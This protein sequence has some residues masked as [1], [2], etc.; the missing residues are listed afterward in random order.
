MIYLD[1]QASTPIH[2]KVRSRMIEVLQSDIGAN[3]HS[4]HFAGQQAIKIIDEARRDLAH[5]F[6]VDFAEIIFTSGATE[7]NNIAIQGVITQALQTRQK[8]EVITSP[9]EHSAVLEVLQN[10]C[11]RYPDRLTVKYLSITPEGI[12]QPESLQG[13]INERTILVTVMHANNEIGTIQPI[14]ALATQVKNTR[15]KGKYPVFHSDGSQAVWSEDINIGHTAIDLYSISG[16][17]CYGPKG[18]GALIIRQGTPIAPL[19]FGGG[20]EYNLRPGTV[21]PFLVAGLASACQLLDTPEHQEALVRI[22]SQ[23]DQLYDTIQLIP[24]IIVNGTRE[25][26]LPHNLHITIPKQSAE[27]LVIAFDLAG[28]ALSAGSACHSG[29]LTPSHVLLALGRSPKEAS[30]SLRISLH[31]F[32]TEKDI[33]TTQNI[34]TQILID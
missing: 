17:K 14:K 3:P 22:R 19:T 28:I 11:I 5:T 8:V 10:L 16:H 33:T 1:S 7:S 29:A 15:E 23:R 21:S 6:G 26:Q 12:V 30:S 9:I 24:D 2:P 31:Q 34:L 13:L 4:T 32:L 20:Q 27:S 25:Q 18:V